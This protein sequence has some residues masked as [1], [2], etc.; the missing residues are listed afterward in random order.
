MDLLSRSKKLT[1]DYNRRTLYFEPAEN[2]TISRSV[3][4]GFL[5]TVAVQGLP[6]DCGYIPGRISCYTEIASEAPDRAI[7]GRRIEGNYDGTN[8]GR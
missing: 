8:R 6:F 5:V 7:D 2:L 3:P 1:I 4:G